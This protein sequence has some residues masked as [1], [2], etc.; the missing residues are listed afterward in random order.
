[1]FKEICSRIRGYH[2]IL[3]HGYDAKGAETVKLALMVLGVLRILG[4]G[5]TFDALEE[6]NAV[7]CDT[8]RFFFHNV[9]CTWVQHVAKD[10]IRMPND[11]KSLCHVMGLYERQELP[12]CV[13]S[14]DC[15]HVCWD[16]Y[17]S[18]MQLTC[19]G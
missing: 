17:P 19:K 11:E 14:V 1:M 7:G 18:S 10:I 5:C 3:E 2:S 6:L 4:S 12:G 8:H 13:G 9:F 16:R 15:V